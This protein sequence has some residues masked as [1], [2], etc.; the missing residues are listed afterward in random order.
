MLVRPSELTE[1]VQRHRA[2]AKTPSQHKDTFCHFGQADSFLL[3]FP[4]SGSPFCLARAIGIDVGC[5]LSYFVLVNNYNKPEQ[6]VDS[7][8]V[9]TSNCVVTDVLICCF[10]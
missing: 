5:V 9:V 6:L 4:S 1:P 8:C 3:I 7:S 10:F 2:G